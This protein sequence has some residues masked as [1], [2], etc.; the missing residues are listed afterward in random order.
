MPLKIPM[1]K[2]LALNV[3]VLEG[4]PLGSNWSWMRSRVSLAC[5]HI[6]VSHMRSDTRVRAVP[7]LSLRVH[8]QDEVQGGHNEKTA[9][10]KPKLSPESS[11]V[12]TLILDF[13]PQNC[14]RINFYCLSHVGYGIFLCSPSCQDSITHLSI[15]PPPFPDTL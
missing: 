10:H 7:A 8:H 2:A 5:S 15:F 14:E 12:G 4:R 3:T 6:L 11:H 13:Q 9:I 1:S